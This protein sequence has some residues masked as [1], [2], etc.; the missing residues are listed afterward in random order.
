MAGTSARPA[1]RERKKLKTRAAIRKAT[2]RLAA[3]QGWEAATIEQIAAAAEVSPSTVIRYFPAKEDILLTD[4][5]DELLLARLRARPA[6]EDPLDSLRAVV[7]DAVTAS[8]AAEPE[9]T[10]LRTRLIVEIPAVRARLTE[11]TARTGRL[12]GSGVAERTGRSPDDLEVRV[13][14]AAV[15]GALREATVHWAE[16]G[17]GDDL[18]PLLDRTVDV[19]K[20]GLTLRSPGP[21]RP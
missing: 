1:L 3:E 5:Q 15:L 2:Y 21:A 14:T 12:L 7:L 18:V 17:Q 20:A 10:R 4:D 6:D 11:T 19:L 16:H 13:F 8:L 9:E